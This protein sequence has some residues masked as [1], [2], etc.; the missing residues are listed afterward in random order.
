M[1]ENGLLKQ[2]EKLDFIYKAIEDAQR[3]IK[4]TDAKA[5]AIIGAWVAILGVI[6]NIDLINEINSS[7]FNIF[8]RNQKLDYFIIL[9]LSIFAIIYII[10]SIWLSF[11]A[12]N[13][14][15][16]P[17]EHVDYNLDNGPM[18]LFYLSSFK[19]DF[20]SKNLYFD[21]NNLKLGKSASDF[22]EQINQCNE[23]DLITE[24]IYELQK[25]SYIRNMKIKRVNTSIE[26]F[27]KFIFVGVLY[28]LYVTGSYIFGFINIGGDYVLDLN[29]N[30]QLFISL[31]V[32]HNIADYLFQT[33]NQAKKKNKGVFNLELLVHC[34]IYTFIVAIIP[35][36]V[37]GY[38]SWNAFFIIFI[39]HLI[40]DN[41]T[42]VIWWSKNIKIIDKPKDSSVIS[43]VDQTFHIIILFIISL[44]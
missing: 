34:L 32:A 9:I 13:P 4:F 26:N 5:G 6:Y 17:T 42:F 37:L 38:F 18:N 19:P 24:L 22:H 1:A 21:S 29:I 3:I 30:S 25:L 44:L 10:K 27:K 36:L 8:I 7:L 23:D 16:S 43:K 15:S 39:S 33:D 20:K 41:R 12:L 28:L 40:I 35:F 14:K 11:T 31:F 2:K